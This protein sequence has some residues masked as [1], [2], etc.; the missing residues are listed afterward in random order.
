MYVLLPLLCVLLPLAL[1]AKQ[2]PL[3]PGTQA[4]GVTHAVGTN[5]FFADLRSGDIYLADVATQ[6]VTRAVR[7][8]SN[9]TAVGIHARN[10][11]LFAAGGGSVIIDIDRPALHVYEVVSGN[12]IASCEV[13]GEEAIVNDV[14]ADSDF[15]Y[16]TDSALG[17]L[18]KLSLAALPKC[19]VETIELPKPLFD[20][21]SGGS[22]NGLIKYKEGLIVG[23]YD[24][25]TIFFVDLINKNKVQQ[26]LASGTI[27]G[28]DG[29]D[30]DRK[31]GGS[32]LFVTQNGNNQVTKW[33]LG[34]DEN[35][36]V[37]AILLQNF[38][39]PD[40]GFPTTVAVSDEYVVATSSRF[41]TVDF[42]KPIP[43]N[44][45]LSLVAFRREK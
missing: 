45:T 43:D 11:R 10:G 15:A 5:F 26:I 33:R 23:N 21:V 39:S 8:P 12:T 7:A 41:D 25:G 2:I 40:L 6:L 30:I 32:L 17:R 4:E 35:R 14:V 42:N 28:P 36:R 22:S 20:A 31:K 16:Y 34:I 27:P 24:L 3:A 9:R 37:S 13:D 44:V 38:T 1:S 29:L 18:Y 19:E